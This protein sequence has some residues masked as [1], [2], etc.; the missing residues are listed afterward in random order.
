M[1]CG[2]VNNEHILSLIA[3]LILS[4]NDILPYCYMIKKGVITK[5]NKHILISII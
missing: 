1:F 3:I 2:F 5:H 4:N